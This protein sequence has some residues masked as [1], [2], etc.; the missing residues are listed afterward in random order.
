MNIPVSAPS[1][2]NTPLSARMRIAVMAA[3]LATLAGCATPVAPPPPPP[4]PPVVKL[5][6][7]RPT[8]PSGAS[9]MM[10]IPAVGTD[11][12]RL[13]VNNGL[14][15]AQTTWNVRSALNVAALNCQTARHADILVNY[16]SFLDRFERPLR[17]TSNAVLKDFQDQY[18]RR[19][20]RSQFDQYMTKVY[21]YFALPPA[22]NE[23]CDAALRVSADSALVASS[24]LDSFSAR[25]LPQLEAVFEDFFRSFENYERNLNNW[26][27]TY[28]ANAVPGTPVPDWV[29]QGTSSNAA[30]SDP[31]IVAT[32]PAPDATAVTS[33]DPGESSA[34]DDTP[35]PAPTESGGIVFTSQPVVQEP[36]DGG[37][38]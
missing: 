26:N 23:F 12:Q 25:A 3:G 38:Q 11:G 22:Q 8:P 29:N 35:A 27:A 13:T 34:A 21:N 33:V 7:P 37:G 17:S 31:V 19:S 2:P 15:T 4:P 18:G 1:A 24:D 20:G 30:S 16:T 36:D 32:Q 5:I 28:G 6:P 10:A 9:A 14:S